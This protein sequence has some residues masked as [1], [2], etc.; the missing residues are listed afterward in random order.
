MYFGWLISQT[1]FILLI[2]CPYSALAQVHQLFFSVGIL[3]YLFV[4]LP[5]LASLFEFYGRNKNQIRQTDIFGFVQ[6]WWKFVVWR[7]RLDRW[8]IYLNWQF[9]IRQ[10]EKQPIEFTHTHIDALTILRKRPRYFATTPLSN[11]STSLNKIRME[12]FSVCLSIVEYIFS[13]KKMN[14]YTANGI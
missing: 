1:I 9:F 12:I 7:F 5:N 10:I 11:I 3:I 2:K 13:K 14:G 4:Y 6:F 8:R